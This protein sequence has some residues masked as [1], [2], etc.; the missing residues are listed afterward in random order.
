[1]DA[2]YSD[3]IAQSEAKLHAAYKTPGNARQKTAESLSGYGPFYMKHVA[4]VDDFFAEA[5]EGDKLPAATK[6]CKTKLGFK[7]PVLTGA[8]FKDPS[9]DN[10]D[11]PCGVREGLVASLVKYKWQA[12]KKEE[13][14]APVPPKAN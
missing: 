12:P 1:V 2:A 13:A 7:M 11:G 9:E 10:V 6:A 14:A 4:R 8:G 5:W 3:G